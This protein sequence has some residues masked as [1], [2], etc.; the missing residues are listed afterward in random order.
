MILLSLSCFVSKLAA[1]QKGERLFARR[2]DEA[3]Q[4][5]VSRYELRQDGFGQSLPSQQ[6][7]SHA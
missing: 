6:E 5:A 3:S 1:Y 2:L 7:A 4:G